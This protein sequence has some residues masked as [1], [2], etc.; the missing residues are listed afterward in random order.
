[1]N[2]LGIAPNT[3]YAPFITNKQ[4]IKNIE[5]FEKL[6]SLSDEKKDFINAMIDLIKQLN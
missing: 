2:I 4:A 6:S 3:I 5:I 1:M